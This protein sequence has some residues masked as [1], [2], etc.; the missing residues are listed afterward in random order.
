MNLSRR[1]STLPRAAGELLGAHVVA[2]PP[3][4]RQPIEGT[5]VEVDGYTLAV[6]CADGVIVAV[7]VEDCL[8]AS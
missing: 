1:S 3:T 5:V 7:D 2:R 8:P 6:L 4:L